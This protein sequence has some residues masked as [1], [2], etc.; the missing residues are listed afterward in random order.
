MTTLRKQLE[1][2]KDLEYFPK[3]ACPILTEY[4]IRLNDEFNDEHKQ[5]LK[6]I[7][8]LLLNSKMNGKTEA[9]RKRLLRWR[10]VTVTYP[11]ILDYYIAAKLRTFENTLENMAEAMTYLAKNKSNI[12]A[13]DTHTSAWT[14]AYTYAAG[15]AT[16]AAA[17]AYSYTHTYAYAD[18]YSYVLQTKLVEVSV[19]TLKLA[20]AIRIEE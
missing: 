2:K 11:M 8:P 15:D 6:P 3:Y 17:D 14:Y 12:Y 5:M 20:A 18:A 19:E 7:I 13:V 10:Y 4:A 9:A 1:L 16:G